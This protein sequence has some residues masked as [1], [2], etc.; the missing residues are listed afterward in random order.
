VAQL[1]AFGFDAQSKRFPSSGTTEDRSKLPGMTAVGSNVISSYHSD[2]IPTPANRWSG[3]NRGNYFNPELDRLVDQSLS[4]VA[5]EEILRLTIQMEK[6]VSSE[7]PGI[8][9]YWHSRAWTHV[10]SLK[11]PKVRLS[12]KGGH[13]TR[14]VHE[15]EW[16][17]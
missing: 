2:N 11:G 15:W 10:S 5:P 17:R 8:F 4:E 3:G 6:L 14:N 1:K 13:P 16:V 12:L 7:V 9:L